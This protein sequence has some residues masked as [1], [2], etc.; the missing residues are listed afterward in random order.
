M[1]TLPEDPSGNTNGLTNMLLTKL[2]TSMR[3]IRMHPIAPSLRNPE[4]RIQ[5][6]S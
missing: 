4:F 5:N 6:I 1:I 3:T 2:S